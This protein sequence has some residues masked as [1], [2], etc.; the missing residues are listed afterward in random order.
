VANFICTEKTVNTNL[1][2]WYRGYMP[3]IP[4]IRFCDDSIYKCTRQQSP[5]SV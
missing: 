4:D 2:P 1:L 5:Y 3:T